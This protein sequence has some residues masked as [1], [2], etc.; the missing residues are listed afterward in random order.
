MNKKMAE[1]K[2]CGGGRVYKT[3]TK[4]KAIKVLIAATV[5]G[6][7]R[8]Q[9]LTHKMDAMLSNKLINNLGSSTG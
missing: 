3:K 7:V 8:S 5:Q 2:G 6:H 4:Q 9:K 1:N